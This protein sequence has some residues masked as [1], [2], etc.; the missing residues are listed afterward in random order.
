MDL[1]SFEWLLSEPG[2]HLLQRVCAEPAKDAL[3]LGA[4]LRKEG[5]AGAHVAAAMTQAFN[6]QHAQGVD[7]NGQAGG[8]FFAPLTGLAASASTNTGSASV[9][10]GLNDV[11][12]IGSGN[13][14]LR[15]DGSNW[16]LSDASSGAQLPMSG[17]GTAADPFVAAG[18][19]FQVNGSAASGDSL[20]RPG[21]RSA[22]RSTTCPATPGSIV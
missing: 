8:N 20:T 15:Y 9:A 18:M 10:V 13:Y 5:Y 2:R 11:G 7:Q 4:A 12:Q 22:Q 16:T 19:S 3:A 14:L 17:S 1:A 6:A 21:T